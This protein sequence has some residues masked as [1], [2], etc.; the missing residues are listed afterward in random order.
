MNDRSVYP[1]GKRRT[2]IVFFGL[3]LGMLLAALDQTIVSTA[4][5]RIT[6][7]LGGFDHYSWVF[8]AYMLGA[9]VTVPL[10][11]KLSDIYGRRPF[12]LLV[13]ALRHLPATRVGIIAMLEPVVA[14]VVAWAWLGESL[15]A[16]QLAGAAIVLGAILL[17]QTA[18]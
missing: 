10:Y 5:P 1:L 18:R 17:A 7:D 9:T 12:F 8:S 13:S 3:M 6:H 15:S 2:L 4:L 16:A 11:G 14:T